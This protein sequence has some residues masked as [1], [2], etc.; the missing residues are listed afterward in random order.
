MGQHF[1]LYFWHSGG[2][3]SNMLHKYNISGPHGLSGPLQ[4]K[5]NSN[6]DKMQTSVLVFS[7]LE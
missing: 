3:L 2:H 6:R 5:N 7:R 1:V 4:N